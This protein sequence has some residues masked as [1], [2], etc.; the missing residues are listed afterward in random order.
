MPIVKAYISEDAYIG[1]VK[2]TMTAEHGAVRI[3]NGSR[4]VELPQIIDLDPVSD[5][6]QVAA[7]YQKQC[8]R[9][10]SEIKRIS[11]EVLQHVHQLGNGIQTLQALSYANVALSGANLA[12]SAIG[13]A[14][15]LNK[16]SEMDGEIKQILASNQVL[17]DKIHSIRNMTVNEKY[18][19]YQKLTT[20]LYNYIRRMKNEALSD[21]LLGDVYNELMEA[22]AFITEMRLNI[23][24]HACDEISP[25]LLFELSSVY[26]CAGSLYCLCYRSLHR[27]DDFSLDER[28]LQDLRHPVELILQQDMH[29]ALYDFFYTRSQALPI[30]RDI[31]NCITLPMFGLASGKTVLDTAQVI[32]ASTFGAEDK[33][34]ISIDDQLLAAIA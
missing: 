28:T 16:L 1:L 23:L 27:E 7:R 26:I 10:S 8:L 17:L 14:M 21:A 4:L 11:N 6:A 24:A 33:V 31:Q 22:S 2:K 20:K 15:I 5:T 30:E 18:A 9:Q 29:D 34:E 13:D 32:A 19:E 25:E 3:K 12:A